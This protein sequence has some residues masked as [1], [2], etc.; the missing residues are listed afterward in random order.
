MVPYVPLLVDS[1][2]IFGPF[3]LPGEE[4]S[5]A[6]NQISLKA[7]FLLPAHGSMTDVFQDAGR[8]GGGGG[9][10]P[11][12]MRGGRGGAGGEGVEFAIPP[13][14]SHDSQHCPMPVLQPQSFLACL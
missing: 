9:A 10:G 14:F 8:V 12:R 3:W 11:V 5:A 1:K 6:W 4:W 2:Y 7:A 13:A